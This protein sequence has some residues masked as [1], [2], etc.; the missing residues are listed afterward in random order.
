MESTGLIAPASLARADDTILAM[1]EL[2]DVQGLLQEIDAKAAG[3]SAKYGEVG[4]AAFV[5]PG[6][7]EKL[8]QNS[9]DSEAETTD[10]SPNHNIVIEAERVQAASDSAEHDV[11]NE[12]AFVDMKSLRLETRSDNP[13]GTDAEAAA[14]PVRHVAFEEPM[15]VDGEPLRNGRLMAIPEETHSNIT[16][17][18]SKRAIVNEAA[19]VD[20]ESDAVDDAA[21]VDVGSD[22]DIEDAF[23]EIEP[24][25][26]NEA[27]FVGIGSLRVEKWSATFLAALMFLLPGLVVFAVL[28]RREEQFDMTRYF[29]VIFFAP[30]SG[31][32][33]FFM[34]L[35]GLIKCKKPLLNE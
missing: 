10:D 1:L 16:G 24:D 26:A 29:P 19:F 4:E 18:S 2:A 9:E 11:V 27:A 34:Y 35:K 5:D 32:V 28:V 7:I 17:D 14:D 21:F 20:V 33:I 30:L 3:N 25:V 31:V 12:A 6:G 15:L 22:V 13:Q 23:V 8:L